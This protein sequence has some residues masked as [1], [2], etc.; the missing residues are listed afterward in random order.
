MR[1]NVELAL[2]TFERAWDAIAQSGLLGEVDWQ[3]AAR[4]EHFTET[5][6]LRE[7]A[8]VILC[9]G[10][11]ESTVRRVF[12]H[13]SLCFFDW[14]SAADIAEAGAQCVAAASAVFNHARKLSAVP[15]H[16][17]ETPLCA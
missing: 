2:A 3:R 7:A 8:W 13:V 17:S 4:P 11:R 6:L 10:F 16:T 12:G 9:G 1:P 15:V 14:E 5:D